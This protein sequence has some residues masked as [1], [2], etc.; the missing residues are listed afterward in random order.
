M[1]SSTVQ[2]TMDFCTLGMFIIGRSALPF[3]LR[4]SFCRYEEVYWS[5]FYGGLVQGERRECR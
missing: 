5:R 1:E 3:R 2:Q 4:P